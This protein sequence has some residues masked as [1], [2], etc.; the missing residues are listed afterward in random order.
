MLGGPF[1]KFCGEN[2]GVKSSLPT[3]LRG[4]FEPKIEFSFMNPL[5]SLRFTFDIKCITLFEPGLRGRGRDRPGPT[6][7]AW[8]RGLKNWPGPGPGKDPL[9]AYKFDTFFG[10]FFKF[11]NKKTTFQ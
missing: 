4:P 10:I 8:G 5:G 11:L 2:I 6:F 1:E 3:I 7:F 9:I